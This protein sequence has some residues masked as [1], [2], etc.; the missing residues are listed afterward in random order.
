M[1]TFTRNIALQ[2]VANEKLGFQ[3]GK[4][5]RVDEKHAFGRASD[6]KEDVSA[7]TVHHAAG[8]DGS[9]DLRHGCDRQNEVRKQLEGQCVRAVGNDFER[10]DAGTRYDEKC[11][12]LSG[13]DGVAGCAV[14][15]LNEGNRIGY[16]C[17]ARFDYATGLRSSGLQ[18]WVQATRSA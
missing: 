8:N 6:S 17:K 4:P 2:V 3:F 13:T 9:Q 15:T 12:P 11:N 18:C 10:L 7:E 1:K 5:E 16:G 14:R